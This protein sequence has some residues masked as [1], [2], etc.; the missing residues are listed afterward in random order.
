MQHYPKKIC[1]TRKLCRQTGNLFGSRR[2]FRAQARVFFV[3]IDIFQ[4]VTAYRPPGSG[5]IS[6]PLVQRFIFFIQNKVR[7]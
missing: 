6:K 1:Q 3:Y 5:K 2:N 7:V 4:I